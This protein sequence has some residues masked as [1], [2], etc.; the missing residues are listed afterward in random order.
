MDQARAKASALSARPRPQR[1]ALLPPRGPGSSRARPRSPSAQAPRDTS[2]FVK[3]PQS[4]TSSN[5]CYKTD[6]FVMLAFKVRQHPKNAWPVCGRC[7][8]ELIASFPPQ[9]VPC[10][11]RFS[12]DWVTCPFAHPGESAQAGA[13]QRWMLRPLPLRGW[14]QRAQPRSRLKRVH[15][16]ALEAHPT[17]APARRREGAAQGPPHAP[18]HRVHGDEEGAQGGGGRVGACCACSTPHCASALHQGTRCC[19]CD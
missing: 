3:L 11:K 14:K 2:T 7:R 12:H 10:S 18:G 9:I 6:A 1:A 13:E 8:G 19:C 4:E 15:S 17:A 5:P 16:S